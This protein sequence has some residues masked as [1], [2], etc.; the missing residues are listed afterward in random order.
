MRDYKNTHAYFVGGGIA[1]LAGACYLIRDCSFPGD[2]I[3]I[4]EELN[5]LGGSND[6]AGNPETGYVIRGGRM[7][8][9]ET[10]ENSWELLLSIPSIDNPEKSVREEIIEFDSQHPT[11]SNARLVD[12]NGEVVDVSSMGFDNEDRIAL[13]KLIVTPEEK[14]NMLKISDWFKPHFFETNF[15]YMWATTFAFQP[16]HSLA[17]LR[18]Y[19]IRFMHEF[20]RIHTLEGVTRTPYNQYDSLILPIKKFLE[21]HNVDFKLKCVVTDLDFKDSD[22][23]TVTKIYYKEEG[24]EKTIELNESDVVFVTNGSMTEGYSLGAMTKP[25]VLNDKGASWKLWDKISKKKQG[26]GNPTVFDDNIQGSKWESFTVTCNNSKFFDLMEKFSRNKAGTGALVTFKDS[27]WF[28]S[29]VLA[30]Q[31]HFRNQ[32]DDVKVFWGY[33][34]YPDNPGNYVKKKMSECTGEEILI[35]LLHHLKFEKEMDDIIGS[36]NCIPC[37]MPFITAQFMPRSIG[38]R[39]QVVPEGSTNLAFIGQFCEIPDDVV[40]T[41][42]YSVRSA[43]IAVYKLFGITRPVEPINQY[44]YDVRTLFKSFVTMFK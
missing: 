28:M 12:N 43:R 6:G 26:L 13:A 7:L 5:V 2:H 8:N 30:H 42:E 27:N 19:M 37:M 20:P 1:S 25:P 15:W 14:L 31:P 36:A 9:D 39:P 32:P 40:F 16:W 3:H 4:F 22:E 24:I 38:D 10:Y 29:I 18:R 44:Q 11:H 34:L 35:E 17:E 41:E 33:G 21:N 23:I